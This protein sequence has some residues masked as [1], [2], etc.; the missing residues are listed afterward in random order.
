MS[1][2]EHS[3]SHSLKIFNCHPKT[4]VFQFTNVSRYIKVHRATLFGTGHCLGQSQI[5]PLSALIVG[6][7]YYIWY[8]SYV[9]QYFKCRWSMINLTTNFS[10]QNMTFFETV[11]NN[12][13]SQIASPEVYYSNVNKNLEH[14]IHM[15]Q[16]HVSLFGFGSQRDE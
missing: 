4:D 15:M 5:M 16:H 7:F 10:K 12:V 8:Y 3:V 9:Q 11:P 13:L 6:S 2:L 1:N 14:A